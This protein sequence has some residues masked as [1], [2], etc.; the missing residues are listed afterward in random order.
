[1]AA[2]TRQLMLELHDQHRLRLHLCQQEHREATQIVGVF[3][4]GLGGVQHAK[5]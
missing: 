4:Q 5:A 2:V 3:R 1:M